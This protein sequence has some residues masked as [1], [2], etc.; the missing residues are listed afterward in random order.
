MSVEVGLVTMF[1]LVPFH[2]SMRVWPLPVLPTAH[3]SVLE[4]AAAARRVPPPGV[5]ATLQLVPSKCRATGEFSLTW[6]IRIA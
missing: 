1:Q 4:T 2:C 5:V 6:Q 3:T